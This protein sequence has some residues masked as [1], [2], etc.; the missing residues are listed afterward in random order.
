[1]FS[2]PPTPDTRN[3]QLLVICH[4]RSNVTSL[5]LSLKKKVKTQ[6]KKSQSCVKIVKLPI[7]KLLLLKKKVKT[8]QKKS[9]SCA[10][11]VKL[12]IK[13]LLVFFFARQGLSGPDN[14]CLGKKIL[15][16]HVTTGQTQNYHCTDCINTF[17]LFLACLLSYIFAWEIP[18]I[19]F[20]WSLMIE[21][22][23]L[24]IFL[25]CWS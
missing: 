2:W 3:Y 8:Q 16:I 23:N 10:K 6:Q 25:M 17:F 14:P 24:K 20:S 18:P 7:T 22:N 12:Q 9:Q 5:N 19:S 13:K 21:I 15:I 4:A 1:M 11:I